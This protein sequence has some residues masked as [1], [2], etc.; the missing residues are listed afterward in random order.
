MEYIS[1]R[2]DTI[3]YFHER[4][5]RVKMFKLYHFELKYI[6]YTLKTNKF[7]FYL[8]T[9]WWKTNNIPIMYFF[10]YN[11]CRITWPNTRKMTSRQRFDVIMLVSL[12]SFIHIPQCGIR[13]L[14]FTLINSKFIGCHIIKHSISSLSIK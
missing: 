1:S 3:E 4:V 13:I 2:R 6:P 8:M 7:S 9:N 11:L 5:A 14:Y 12:T 10:M